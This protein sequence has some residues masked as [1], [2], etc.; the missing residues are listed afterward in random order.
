MSN[1]YDSTAQCGKKLLIQVGN[2][3]EENLEFS[4]PTTLQA[5][6]PYQEA[7]NVIPWLEW[8]GLDLQAN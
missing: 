3:T 6:A 7:V 5:Y 2:E 8:M 4:F 1:Q